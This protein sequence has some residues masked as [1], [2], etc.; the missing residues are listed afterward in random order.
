[1][2]GKAASFQSSTGVNTAIS[3]DSHEMETLLQGRPLR[4]VQEEYAAHATSIS[5]AGG[6]TD[7]SS[8]DYGWTYQEKVIWLADRGY[9]YWL[10]A[11]TFGPDWWDSLTPAQ[12]LEAD[13]AYN[14]YAKVFSNDAM[15]SFIQQDDVKKQHNQ[16][17]LSTP[18]EIARFGPVGF[19]LSGKSAMALGIAASLGVGLLAYMQMRR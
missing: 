2:A 16:A 1:M 5:D 9:P 11:H 12:K 13:I 10:A 4:E 7:S 18:G 19:K 6:A 3:E 17:V 15:Q 8:Y 14:P